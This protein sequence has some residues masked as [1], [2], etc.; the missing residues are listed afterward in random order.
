MRITAAQ[1]E[2]TYRPQAQGVARGPGGR[3]SWFTEFLA[4]EQAHEDQAHEMS[5]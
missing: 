3:A 2:R 5:Y 1:I 4:A